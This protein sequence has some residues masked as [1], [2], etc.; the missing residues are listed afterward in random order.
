M[1]FSLKKSSYYQVN[2]KTEHS[3]LSKVQLSKFKLMTIANFKDWTVES[4]TAD[5][6]DKPLGHVEANWVVDDDTS[7][8]QTNNCLPSFFYSNFNTFNKTIEAELKAGPPDDDFIGFALNFQP[9]DTTN[10]SPDILVVDWAGNDDNR[11]KM[12]LSHITNL[13]SF[14]GF[15]HLDYIKEAKNLSTVP[16]EPNRVYKFK[17]LCTES[18]IQVWVDGSLEFDVDGTFTDGRFACYACGQ[19][20]V[21][22]RNVQYEADGGGDAFSSGNWE[23]VSSTKYQPSDLTQS[24]YFGNS[25]AVSGDKA[26]VGAYLAYVSAGHAYIYQWDGTAWQQQQKLE[27]EDK[28]RYAHL[29]YS[30]AISGEWAIAGAPRSNVT[31]PSSGQTSGSQEGAVYIFKLEEET[32]QQTQKIRPYYLQP[33]DKFGTSV[34]I[35]GEVLIVGCPYGDS[36]EAPNIGT[37]Y[38]Y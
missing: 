17:F 35:S 32:W 7:V 4:Y 15:T 34:D 16:W 20:D 31:P 30:V 29:G 10:P 14:L 28:E 5:Q 24:I 2:S 27:D 38:I 3:I 12:Q 6:F 25:V 22:F 13:P 11:P 23:L 37:A 19:R 18:R 21:T 8:T 33:R 26:I 1:S 9:G 36:P